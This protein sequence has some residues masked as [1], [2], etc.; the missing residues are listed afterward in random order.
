MNNDR[1]TGLA[2]N[3]FRK[4]EEPGSPRNFNGTMGD[5][6]EGGDQQRPSTSD[7]KAP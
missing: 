1:P 2:R 3:R 4:S 6:K 5:F 7:E